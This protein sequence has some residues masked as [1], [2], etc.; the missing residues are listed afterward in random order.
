[1]RP[2]ATG[3]S[4]AASQQL[5]PQNF[6]P[7]SEW[8]QEDEARFL[9]VYLPGFAVEQLTITPDYSNRTIKVE[10]R[11][12]LPNNRLLPVNETFD[13]PQ[14][15]DLTKMDKQFGRGI[16]MLKMPRNV[17]PQPVP[18][19][20]TTNA[21]TPQETFTPQEKVDDSISRKDEDTD[22]LK[23]TSDK[24]PV[25]PPV[26]TTMDKKSVTAAAAKSYEQKLVA[27]K[28]KN[29]DA[30]GEPAEGLE[31][32]VQNAGAK[33]EEIKEQSKASAMTSAM[34]VAKVEEQ[35]KVKSTKSAMTSAMDVAKVEEKKQE[36]STKSADAKGYDSAK[37]GMVKE[38]NEDRKLIVNM[39]TAILIIMGVGA[40]LF[41]TLGHKLA[42]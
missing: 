17:I 37:K 11:R 31:N 29:I 16:L 33:G 39:G 12:Q 5:P 27:K 40:S 21:T 20:E 15:C 30:N 4:A 18:Q 22:P 32:L 25:V 38:L 23:A 35:K 13:I 28:E 9:W 14:D 19:Q 41:Y 8:K 42:G 26:A 36:K 6:K 24:A 1:M 10:G 7:K 3:I 2:R 34:D